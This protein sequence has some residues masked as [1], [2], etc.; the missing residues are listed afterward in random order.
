MSSL[1]TPTPY[2]DINAVLHD[3]E[4]RIRAILGNHFVG[5]Y[6]YGSLAVGDFDPR[7]SDIDFIVVTDADLSD[8][9][10][11]ALR[12]MH[13]RFDES[14]SVWAAKVEAAYIPLEALRHAGPT[15]AK[16]PQIEKHK[17]LVREPL[18]M[19][20]AFQR[21]TLLEHGIVVSGPELRTLIGPADPDALR[22]AIVPITNGWLE[23]AR[24]DPD[25]LAWVRQQDARSFVVLTLCRSLWTLQFG[26][27]TSKAAA[28]RWAQEQ[29]EPRWARLIER[30]LEQR[31][32]AGDIPEGEMEDTIALIRFTLEEARRGKG[33]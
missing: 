27:V 24:H 28:A 31:S 9:L 13:A 5:M 22:R 15:A 16:Y 10:C 18:E 6:V 7:H 19:G 23:Q 1:L 33:R 25:W 14:G 11:A 2:A 8:D 29:L 30:S 21:H 12:E 26:S 4:G 20:W 32:S 3:F 17:T